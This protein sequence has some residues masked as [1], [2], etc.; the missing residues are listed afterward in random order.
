MK[1]SQ[2]GRFGRQSQVK[3]PMKVVPE[4]GAEKKS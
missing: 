1:R 3:V 4:A 2:A